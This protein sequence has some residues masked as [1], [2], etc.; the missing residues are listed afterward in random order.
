MVAIVVLIK[1]YYSLLY[2][3]NLLTSVVSIAVHLSSYHY[4]IGLRRAYTPFVPVRPKSK[5]T[6]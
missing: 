4:Y 1:K 5:L 6:N 2:A 3:T